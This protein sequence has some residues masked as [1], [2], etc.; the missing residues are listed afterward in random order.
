MFI[1][2]RER[3]REIKRARGKRDWKKDKKK[4]IEKERGK[5][6]KRRGQDWKHLCMRKRRQRDSEIKRDGEGRK[7]RK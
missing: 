7:V 4:D 6:L 1:Q 2:D 5:G 3:E